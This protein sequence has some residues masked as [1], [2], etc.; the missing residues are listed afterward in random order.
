[1][2]SVITFEQKR[3]AKCCRNLS[4][5]FLPCETVCLTV[6]NSATLREMNLV[7]KA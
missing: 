1:M 6:N 4:P 3:L 2:I 7:S 5:K